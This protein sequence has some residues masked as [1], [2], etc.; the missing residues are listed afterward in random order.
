MSSTVSCDRAACAGPPPAPARCRRAR[1]PRS[2]RA[3]TA[4]APSTARRRPPRACRPG[5]SAA[6]RRRPR[7]SSSSI[8]VCPIGAVP[9]KAPAMRC[10]ARSSRNAARSRAS[11]ICSGRSGRPGA[12]TAPP[13]RIRRTHHGSRK[14]LSC[15][16]TIRPGADDRAVAGSTRALGGRLVGAVALAVLPRRRVL[17]DRLVG[18]VR[19]GVAARDEHVVADVERGRGGDLRRVVARGVDRGVPARPLQRRDV[20]AVA[21][22]VLDA[23]RRRCRG[24]RA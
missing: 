17:V 5:S 23:V 20:G 24:A 6:R 7:S 19:V 13:S 10:S 9:L 2:A 14:T 15:G 22:D 3:A 21:R 12:G 16:P 4:A 1:C 11:M 18:P 8:V